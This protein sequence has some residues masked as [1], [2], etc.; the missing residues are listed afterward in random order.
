MMST[1][2]APSVICDELPAV[3]LPSGLKAG[4]SCASVSAVVPG[5]MPSSAVTRSFDS[6]TFLVSLSRRFSATGTISFSKRPSFV[7]CSAS[8]WLRAPKASRS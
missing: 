3:T 7:A 5:R 1:A 8:C 6:M 2:A 4:F